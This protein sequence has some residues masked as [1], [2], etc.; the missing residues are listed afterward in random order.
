MHSVFL[1]KSGVT[2][3]H[4]DDD[5]RPA[6]STAGFWGGDD[7]ARRLTASSGGDASPASLGVCCEARNRAQNAPAC[8]SPPR[9]APEVL[10]GGG[11]ATDGGEATVA[12]R[13]GLGG[14]GGSAG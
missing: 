8:P 5:V 7:G 3:R 4:Q 6:D 10:H 1:V 11:K 14:G 13:L 12:A 2:E 9:A